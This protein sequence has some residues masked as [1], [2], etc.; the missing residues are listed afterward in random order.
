[1]HS[2]E[3]KTKQNWASGRSKEVAGLQARHTTYSHCTSPPC[4]LSDSLLCK[5]PNLE[6]LRYL[7]NLAMHSLLLTCFLLSLKFLVSCG[8][9][10]LSYF[11]KNV[12][13]WL[14]FKY[15]KVKSTS[16][17]CLVKTSCSFCLFFTFSP[18]SL[19]S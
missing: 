17:L 19:I 12:K 15:L 5:I 10:Y 1:M 11:G 6:H 7:V 3:N 13:P 8:N 9:S 14:T 18:V 2:L 4:G 16:D